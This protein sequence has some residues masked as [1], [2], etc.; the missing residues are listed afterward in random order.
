MAYLHEHE[1]PHCG[2]R[3]GCV[4]THCPKKVPCPGHALARIRGHATRRQALAAADRL[5]RLRG[6]AMARAEGRLR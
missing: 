5:S 2:R 6:R 1:C 3:T 4:G